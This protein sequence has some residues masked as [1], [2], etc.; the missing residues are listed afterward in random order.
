MTRLNCNIISR[1]EFSSRYISLS[2]FAPAISRSVMPG[3]F[4]MVKIP[5]ERFFLRR[6]FSVCRTA[7]DS[8][9]IVF[10]VVGAGTEKLGQMKKGDILNIIGPLGNGYP[11]MTHDPKQGIPF[12]LIAGGTGIASLYFLARCLKPG[13]GKVSSPVVFLGAR[14][15]KELIFRPEL[16]KMGYEVLTATDDGSAG[17]KG[18]VTDLFS[19]WLHS[20]KGFRPS[21]IYS[22]GPRLMLKKTAKIA[23]EENVPCFISMEEKMAC[24]I[25]VCMGCAVKT[26]DKKEEYKRACKE[27][28]VFR[29]EEIEWD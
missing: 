25:G 12:V 21:V 2:F 28:P 3:Q 1:K 4:V 10:K 20:P 22:C 9:D 19:S 6:P 14:N 13:R 23:E 17:R 18:F 16:I 11:F 15:R 26:S 7:R 5:G 29:A 27:G 24:G 8:F